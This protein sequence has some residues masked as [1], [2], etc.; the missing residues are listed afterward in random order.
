MKKFFLGFLIGI[1]MGTTSGVW[2]KAE[3]IKPLLKDTYQKLLDCKGEY[4]KLNFKYYLVVDQLTS[5]DRERLGL[6]SLKPIH[7]QEQAKKPHPPTAEEL[8]QHEL[9]HELLK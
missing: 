7:L 8:L 1:I 4:S 6:V 9:E 3:Q 5:E 2:W